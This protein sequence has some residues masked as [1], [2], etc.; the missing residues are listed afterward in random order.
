[1]GVTRV[2]VIYIS[3]TVLSRSRNQKTMRL[4]RFELPRSNSTS[5]SLIPS[6]SRRI[7]VGCIRSGSVCALFVCEHRL[8][9]PFLFPVGRNEYEAIING[10]VG[11]VDPPAPSSV[12][13]ISSQHISQRICDIGIDG[14]L[15]FAI[16]FD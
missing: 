4:D 16:E 10:F 3:P 2:L 9:K 14:I 11:A 1:M 15:F 6:K 5:N 13:A 12:L 7:P 8:H